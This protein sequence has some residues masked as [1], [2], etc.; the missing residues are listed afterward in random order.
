MQDTPEEILKI[1]QAIFMRK[2]PSERFM[3]GIEM[4]EEVIKLVEASIRT[5]SPGISDLDLKIER[6]KRF[7]SNDFSTQEMNN[8][9]DHLKKNYNNLN[10]KKL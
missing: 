4:I 9:I 6:F 10:F 1:Q 8:I 2:T 3:M 5:S 7:Y